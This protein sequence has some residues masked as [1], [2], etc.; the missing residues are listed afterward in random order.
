LII[1]LLLAEVTLIQEDLDLVTLAQFA[2]FVGLLWELL[3]ALVD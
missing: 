1:L 2:L 3:L